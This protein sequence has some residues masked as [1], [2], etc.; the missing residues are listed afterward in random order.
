MSDKNNENSTNPPYIRLYNN[1]HTN[2]RC[3]IEGKKLHFDENLVFCW[4]F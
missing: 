2:M 1:V 4:D 3:R